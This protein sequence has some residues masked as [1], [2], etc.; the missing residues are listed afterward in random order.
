MLFYYIS[1]YKEEGI[2]A[3]VKLKKDINRP[4]ISFGKVILYFKDTIIT[5]TVVDKRNRMVKNIN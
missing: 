3:S 4:K 1:V 2:L 5:D